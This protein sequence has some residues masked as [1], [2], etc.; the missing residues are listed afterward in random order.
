MSTF[1]AS[2]LLRGTTAAIVGVGP[3]LGRDLALRFAGAGADLV[4]SARRQAVLDAVA[5]EVC[6]LGRRA[7][8]ITAD[9]TSQEDVEK[10]FETIAARPRRLDTVVYNAFVPPSMLSLADTSAETWARNFEVH[11]IGAARV[12]NAAVA[13]LQASSGSLVFINTQATRRSEPR[14]GSYSATK[15]AL[16]SVA[17]TLAGELGPLGV[18]VNSVVPGQIMGPALQ[19]YYTERAARRDTTLEVVL[20]Q[21]ARGMALRRIATGTEVADAAIFFASSLASGI[22]GQS[23]DVNAGNWYE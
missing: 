20:E 3:G 2:G 10:M 7:D 13:L 22:T 9:V 23:L 6:A 1:P 21:V 17:R 14:R 19:A 16:L 12:A 5:T 8:T 11:V 18:R 4:L 15:S